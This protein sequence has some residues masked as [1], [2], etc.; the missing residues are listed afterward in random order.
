MIV[1]FSNLIESIGIM[2]GEIGDLFEKMSRTLRR[3]GSIKEGEEIGLCGVSTV[4]GGVCLG[5]GRKSSR[6][7]AG[8]WSREGLVRGYKTGSSEQVMGEGFDRVVG[9]TVVVARDKVSIS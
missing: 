3:D 2:E 9:D 4:V 6:V 8:D 5:R 7:K 1:T